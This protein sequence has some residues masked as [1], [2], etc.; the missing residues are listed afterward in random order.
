MLQAEFAPA[1]CLI[2]PQDL[3]RRDMLRE[4][5]IA[6]GANIELIEAIATWGLAGDRIV[7]VE[8]ILNVNR[9]G[10]MLRRLQ[11]SAAHSHFFAWDLAFEETVRRH[12]SRP[13]QL[14][15]S[16]DEM[17]EWYHGWQ[18]LDFVEEVRVDA[19]TT[20]EE[21]VELIRVAIRRQRSG[22][23]NGSAVVERLSIPPL[24]NRH[25][26]EAAEPRG[27]MKESS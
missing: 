13:K 3:V 11:R 25:D 24:P 12:A 14:D 23:V 22:V 10:R 2:V 19:A 16:A 26:H 6:G 17:A 1:A 20:A 27:A 8:G 18:P 15:F 4:L 7:V 5:D 21:V 9:Y